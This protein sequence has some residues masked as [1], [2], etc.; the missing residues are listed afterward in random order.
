MHLGPASTSAIGRPDALSSQRLRIYT[1]AALRGDFR[2]ESRPQR[3]DDG[4][5]SGV[6]MRYDYTDEF[7]FDNPTATTKLRLF[8]DWFTSGLGS[9]YDYLDWGARIS[10]ARPV[11]TP[12]TL[13]ALQVLNAFS[14]PIDGDR[15]PNQ[16]R[17]SLGGDLQLHIVALG[18][19]V[20]DLTRL[21]ATPSDRSGA[22]AA[23]AR[24]TRQ[25]PRPA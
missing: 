20:L 10:L 15:V 23:P 18:V 16:G 8:G 11:I 21:A 6:G 17:Y 9:T 13:V 19:I 4:V 1:L 5:L 25:G 2:D 7:A 22:R 24:R 14:T 3:G 12:R